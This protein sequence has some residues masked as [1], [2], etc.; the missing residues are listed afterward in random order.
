MQK[1]KDL[2]HRT[3]NNNGK[4]T[5]PYYSVVSRLAD[6][7]VFD[8]AKDTANKG[9]LMLW[10]GYNGDNQAFTVIQE[11]GNYYFKCRLGGYLT[12]E[13]PNDGAKFYLSKDKRPESVFRLQE[14]KE[15]SHNYIIYTYCNK[16]IDVYNCKKDNGTLIIQYTY[17][18]DKNQQWYLN[19][20]KNLTDSSSGK[21]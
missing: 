15:G 14:T 10:D 7:R 17:N 12:V 13:G 4:F 21:A 18:G 19:D 5:R 20:P 9:F 16:V 1:I 2:F 8:I 3:Q 6:T 11:G